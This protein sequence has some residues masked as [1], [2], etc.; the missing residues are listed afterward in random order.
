MNQS[1][2]SAGYND[3]SHDGRGQMVNDLESS[4]DENGPYQQG[5][6]LEAIR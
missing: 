3:Q 5:N 4:E 1:Q 2:M 6:M